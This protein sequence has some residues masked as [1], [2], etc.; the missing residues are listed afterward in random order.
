MRLLD[1]YS[2]GFFLNP[3]TPS[4][5]TV[6]SRLPTWDQVRT[7]AAPTLIIT[8]DGDIPYLQTVADSLAARL[9]RAVRATVPGGGHMINLIEPEAYNRRVLEFLTSLSR[10]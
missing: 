6:R 5:A 1:A 10:P 4:A 2:G 7:I 8:G 3:A 9:P